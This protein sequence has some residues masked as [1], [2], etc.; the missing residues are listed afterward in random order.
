MSHMGPL[1]R[2]SELGESNKVAET[3]LVWGEQQKGPHLDEKK[4]S[5]SKNYC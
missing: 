4:L 2:V 1:V 5:L 3:G